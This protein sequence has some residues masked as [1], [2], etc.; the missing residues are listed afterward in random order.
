MNVICWKCSICHHLDNC[1]Y[2]LFCNPNGHCSD[3]L[4]GDPDGCDLNICSSF[5]SDSS[6]CPKDWLDD[7]KKYVPVDF[8][9][10]TKRN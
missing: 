9:D 4:I 3:Y 2:V 1:F 5:E 8:E 10:E 7:A 6:S